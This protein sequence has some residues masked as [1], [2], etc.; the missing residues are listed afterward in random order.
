MSICGE[1]V[2]GDHLCQLQADHIV[3]CTADPD[4][5]WIPIPEEPFAEIAPRLFQG[6][7]LTA[8]GASVDPSELDFDSVL[9]LYRS[10]PWCA[11]PINERRFLFEDGKVIPESVQDAVDWAWSQWAL[12]KKR[13][14]VRCQAGLNRSGLIVALVLIRDGHDPDDAIRLVRGRRSPYALVNRHFVE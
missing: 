14:L 3:P 7:T 9:T 11:A 1:P 4:G 2:G 8:S 5:G 10:A 6:G 12:Q 13:L